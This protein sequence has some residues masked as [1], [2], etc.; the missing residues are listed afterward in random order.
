VPSFHSRGIASPFCSPYKS[1][2]LITRLS[3]HQ[4]MQYGMICW[5]CCKITFRQ[6][7]HE[8]HP[9][10]ITRSGWLS[11]L[12]IRENKQNSVAWVRERTI[13]T[14]RPTLVSEVS[15]N[16]C[17]WWVQRG[18]RERSPRPYYRFLH[19][20]RYIFFQAAPHSLTH[21]LSRLSGTRSRPG[22]AQKMW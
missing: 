16:F 8:W 22:T 7:R 20:I 6:G 12:Q 11:D 15:S 21:S 13:P 4:S 19:R 14:E 5:Q 3:L 17:G 2:K 18:Q 9:W 10:N 1:F